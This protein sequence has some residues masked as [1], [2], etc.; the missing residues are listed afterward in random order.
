MLDVWTLDAGVNALGPAE[1]NKYAKQLITINYPL[2]A[3][4]HA[5]DH[6]GTHWKQDISMICYFGGRRFYGMESLACLVGNGVRAS[7][8]TVPGECAGD[9]STREK[10]SEIVVHLRWRQRGTISPDKQ[11]SSGVTTK[12]EILEKSRDGADVLTKTD[13]G[14]W[15]NPC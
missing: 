3:Q 12:R 5:C 2:G 10:V 14:R 6:V 4:L 7:A 13:Q 1:R 11:W 15:S 9:T 8:E